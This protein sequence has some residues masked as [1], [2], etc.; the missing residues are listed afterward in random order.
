MIDESESSVDADADEDFAEAEAVGEE[1]ESATADL[2]DATELAEP[3]DALAKSPA[4]P[5]TSSAGVEDERAF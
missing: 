4:L 3:A 5:V 1:L 2:T